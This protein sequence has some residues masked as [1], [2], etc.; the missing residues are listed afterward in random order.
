VSSA[1][2]NTLRPMRSQ[3]IDRVGEIWLEASM[4]AHGFVPADFWRSQL[5]TMKQELLPQAECYVHVGGDRI[6]GF[7]A[8][9]SD[10]IH[11]LFV[12]PESQRQGIGTSLLSHLKESHHTLRLHVYQRN[13]DATGFYNANGFVITGE[14]SCPHT[15]C[16]EFKME[17]RKQ[18]NLG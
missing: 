16:A 13:R 2:E 6:D 3:D 18:P 4:K 9:D 5:D 15:G 10:F 12:A 17:W 14:A 7:I 1:R 11:G 8:V